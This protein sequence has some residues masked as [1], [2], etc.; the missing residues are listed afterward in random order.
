M[1]KK[2]KYFRIYK[3]YINGEINHPDCRTLY[4]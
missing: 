2:Y 1:F 3:F 4:E